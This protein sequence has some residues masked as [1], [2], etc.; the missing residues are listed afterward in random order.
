MQQASEKKVLLLA[1]VI[2]LLG[3]F[4]ASFTGLHH[5]GTTV[6]K[7]RFESTFNEGDLKLFDG[8][9]L[10]GEYRTFY[11]LNRNKEL[12]EEDRGI[13][14]EK[15]KR[16]RPRAKAG[17]CNVGKTRCGIDENVVYA[18][19]ENELG[20]PEWVEIPCDRGMKC[21]QRYTSSKLKGLS[22]REA[23]CEYPFSG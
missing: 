14:I 20:A 7:G 4:S 17:D 18:C 11:D 22:S 12:D 13:I 5:A 23:F 2:L 19:Q 8:Y 16:Y 9:R 3:F 10:S 6:E 21:H 15:I 1:A